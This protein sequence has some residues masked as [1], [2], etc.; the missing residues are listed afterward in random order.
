M[1]RAYMEKGKQDKQNRST[2]HRKLHLNQKRVP[3][4][5]AGNL[6]GADE[7]LHVMESGHLRRNSRDVK[8]L[9]QAGETMRSSGPFSYTA[10]LARCAGPLLASHPRTSCSVVR[11]ETL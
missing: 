2:K 1:D 10:N 4:T 6:P 7:S 5:V 11:S 3:S 9:R 8:F